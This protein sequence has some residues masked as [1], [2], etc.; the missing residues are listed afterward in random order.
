MLPSI[1][2]RVDVSEKRNSTSF[3]TARKRNST[4]FGTARACRLNRNPPGPSYTRTDMPRSPALPIK[5]LSP[6]QQ[7]MT[8]HFVSLLLHALVQIERRAAP[9][10]DVG[11]G[12]HELV[13]GELVDGAQ[14]RL[15]LGIRV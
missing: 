13:V 14:L 7:N 5:F 11:I 3:G 8:G 4:S 1:G 10:R 6:L 15:A 9:A 2:S 12:V